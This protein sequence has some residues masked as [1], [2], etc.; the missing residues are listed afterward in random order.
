MKT[1][2]VNPSPNTH[3]RRFVAHGAAKVAGNAQSHGSLPLPEVTYV[4]WSEWERVA[5]KSLP[6]THQDLL[7]PA[8]RKPTR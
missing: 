2:T 3:A 6:P 4:D 5:A 1:L 7:A 8:L